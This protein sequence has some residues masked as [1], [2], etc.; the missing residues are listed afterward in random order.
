LP[1]VS[2]Y[3]TALT[4]WNLGYS[5]MLRAVTVRQLCVLLFLIEV[6]LCTRNFAV[7]CTHE[8]T[9]SLYWR[10]YS[11]M[12]LFAV[13]RSLTSLAEAVCWLHSH[14]WALWPV[15]WSVLFKVLQRKAN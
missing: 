14:S 4:D 6:P 5:L 1:P 15:S 12:F 2:I 10:P 13:R 11:F 7:C 3:K 9:V 8:L